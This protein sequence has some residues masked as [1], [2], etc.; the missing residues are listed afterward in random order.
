MANQDE[1]NLARFLTVQESVYPQVVAELRARRKRIHWMW[2][3]FPQIIGLG[4]SAISQRYAI[5]S[6]AEA[7]AY[8]AHP[9]LGQRLLECVTIL[10]EGAE[11]S[12]FR[13]F[14]QPDTMKFQSSLTLFAGV[15][16]P[17]SI[18]EQALEM[19][20]EGQRCQRTEAFLA[21][22]GD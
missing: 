20:F 3:I 10:L 2:F 13:I 15:S 9:I 12:A 11:K 16:E 19:F 21:G 5:R 7:R 6:V 4:R 1:F 8:L 17:G 18:F 22:A 14:G